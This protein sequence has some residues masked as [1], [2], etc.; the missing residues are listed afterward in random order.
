MERA[1][2]A[3]RLPAGES[4]GNLS[5]APR[6]APQP[7]LPVPSIL[8]L[9]PGSRHTTPHSLLLPSVGVPTAGST[10]ETKSGTGQLEKWDPRVS[11]EQGVLGKRHVG[12]QGDRRG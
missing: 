6:S 4:P 12:V 10:W 9:P 1:S 8:I 3:A 7:V 11:F 5:R 2:R